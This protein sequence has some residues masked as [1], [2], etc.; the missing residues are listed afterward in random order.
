VN[1]NER[2]TGPPGRDGEGG[3]KPANVE[4]SPN[5]STN[6]TSRRQATGCC[7]SAGSTPAWRYAH[8]WREGFCYGFRDA[9]RL[10][11]REINDP[12]VWVVLTRIAESYT[13]AGSDR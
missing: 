12:E 7:H 13:L 5:S 9:L 8:A 10:A 2:D 1:S 11:A 4:E 6:T 3:P